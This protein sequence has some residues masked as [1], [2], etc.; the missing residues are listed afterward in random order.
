MKQ[1]LTITLQDVLAVNR[2]L[3]ELQC[4][5]RWSELIVTPGKFTELG[6]QA[7]N[8][9]ISFFWATEI[10]NTGVKVDFSKFAKLA[11]S[12]GFEKT[13]KCDIPEANLACI[14]EQAGISEEDFRAA[15][16]EKVE[17]NISHDF[18]CYLQV[19]PDCLEARIY[20]AATKVA[21]LLELR[22]IP[23][24]IDE[25]D[26]K[27]KVAQVQAALACYSTL[28]C[29]EQIMSAQYQE[30]FRN[31]LKLQNRIR[32][33]KHPNIVSCS[34]LGHLFDTA[35]FAYLMSL[36]AKPGDETLATRFFFMG[37]FHD[38]PEAWTGDMPSPV[39]DSI[40]GL[41]KATE[42]FENHVMKEHVYSHL[43]Q[44]MVTPFRAVMLEDEG[45]AENKALLKNADHLAAYDE[46]WREIEAGSR[47]YYYRDVIKND[48]SKRHTLP[49]TFCK[50]MEKLYNECLGI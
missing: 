7:L 49:P 30:I 18:S 6:K 2:M 23:E 22:A 3:S 24:R 43:P 13:I 11:L 40:P 25:K 36:E 50:L 27:L 14:L 4:L 35:V 37:I 21:T 28:P 29:Y 15:V 8:C 26:Y 38:F 44:H 45:N 5:R 10:S 19:E 46:C 1:Q 32:W 34:V 47:H 41:R 12:R 48:I 16:I 39:K 9:S 31:F 17:N 33:A 42:A 20:R